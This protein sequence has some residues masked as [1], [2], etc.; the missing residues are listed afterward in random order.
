[1]NNYRD[2]FI[3]PEYLHYFKQFS[4]FRDIV[5]PAKKKYSKTYKLSIFDFNLKLSLNKYNNNLRYVWKTNGN[6]KNDLLYPIINNIIGSHIKNVLNYM[7]TLNISVYSYKFSEH[8]RI[9]DIVGKNGTN[10]RYL[11]NRIANICK[12]STTPEIEIDYS[13]RIL[14]VHF[15]NNYCEFEVEILDQIIDDY[16]IDFTHF[17]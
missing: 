9:G 16:L 6:I 15:N 2:T 11:M 17:T 4:D 12:C 14:H 5:L 10:I 1:M 3:K 13:S 7:K 8:Y